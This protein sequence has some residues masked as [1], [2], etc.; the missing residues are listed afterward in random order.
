[1]PWIHCWYAPSRH[2]YLI[3]LSFNTCDNELLN[4]LPILLPQFAFL[5]FWETTLSF[6]VWQLCFRTLWTLTS[7]SMHPFLRLTFEVRLQGIGSNLSYESVKQCSCLGDVCRFLA[8]FWFIV[9]ELGFCLQW[10]VVFSQ[11]TCCLSVLGWR[12]SLAGLVLDPS[13]G[14]LRTQHENSSLVSCPHD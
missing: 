5:R 14:W 10:W 8:G 12:W 3:S 2:H 11:P 9:T 13:S 7:T 4:G 1:M 6:S